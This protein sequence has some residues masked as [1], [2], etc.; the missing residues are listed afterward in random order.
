[1]E[2]EGELKVGS[3]GFEAGEAGWPHELGGAGLNELPVNAI[4]TYRLTCL[5][6]RPPAVMVF[7]QTSLGL[8][9]NPVPHC[10]HEAS[11]PTIRQ[12]C[13][14]TMRSMTQAFDLDVRRSVSGRSLCCPVNE[15]PEIL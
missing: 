2:E 10:K 14:W 5:G 11:L 12:Q 1:M 15:G 3:K 9:S 4:P 7:Q 8:L 13:T 6:P